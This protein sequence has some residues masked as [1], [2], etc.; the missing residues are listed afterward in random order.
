MKPISLFM[1][2]LICLIPPIPKFE[3]LPNIPNQY[4]KIII[5]EHYKRYKKVKRNG[6][7]VIPKF[8]VIIRGR[9]DYFPFLVIIL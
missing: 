6:N 3:L 4:S 9:C 1:I 8:L 5:M 2:I 7:T